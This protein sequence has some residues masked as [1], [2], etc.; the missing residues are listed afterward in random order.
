MIGGVP[1]P[2]KGALNLDQWHQTASLHL[3]T[4]TYLP[5]N[6]SLPST[7]PF[8]PQKP[9]IQP[10]KLQAPKA[11]VFYSYHFPQFKSQQQKMPPGPLN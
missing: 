3:T 7:Q 8:F 5:L 1:R 10:S 6:T 9:I 4:P 11:I 2:R